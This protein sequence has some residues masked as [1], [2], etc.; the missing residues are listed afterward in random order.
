MNELLNH[1]LIICFIN[2]F[3]ELR[4]FTELTWLSH[5]TTTEWFLRTTTTASLYY[6]AA[7]SCTPL[8]LFYDA[9]SLFFS[10]GITVTGNLARSIQQV[11][12]H[13]E[14][15]QVPSEF[16]RKVRIFLS[17]SPPEWLVPG[18]SLD[19]RDPYYAP[20]IILTHLIRNIKN[21]KHIIKILKYKIYNK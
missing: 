18:D 3:P 11:M 16:R 20:L 9:A 8:T 4:F 10:D 21:N 2:F 15:Q 7:P 19:W 14:V 1:V 13:I 12:Y 5:C 6:L 17:G